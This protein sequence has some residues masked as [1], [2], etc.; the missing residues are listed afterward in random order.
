MFM[1]VS[2]N[3]LVRRIF[4]FHSWH[5]DTLDIINVDCKNHWRGSN[6]FST[7]LIEDFL[8]FLQFRESYSWRWGF[9]V[10]LIV[11]K[12]CNG[13]IEFAAACF[14]LITSL[15]HKSLCIGSLVILGTFWIFA[16]CIVYMN[17]NWN[18]VILATVLSTVF[19]PWPFSKFAWDAHCRS[20]IKNM[21]PKS[22]KNF[23]YYGFDF[24]EW[25]ICMDALWELEHFI[26][27]LV[28]HMRETKKK[29][30]NSLCCYLLP[31]NAYQMYFKEYLV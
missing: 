17:W 19:S 26:A 1:Y 7:L 3:F 27:C 25:T 29:N 10:A 11:F 21:F 30:L 12:I 8:E 23:T 24:V 13:S 2:S 5:S 9:M 16:L 22:F 6:N 31:N 28:T 20:Q 14:H 15:K 18:Y 4:L